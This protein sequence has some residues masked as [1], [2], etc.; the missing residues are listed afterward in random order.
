MRHR[1]ALTNSC[2]RFSAIRSSST[3]ISCLLYILLSRVNR[4]LWRVVI[5]YNTK[6]ILSLSVSRKLAGFRFK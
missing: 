2:S 4:L 3:V 6:Y 5:L 1:R